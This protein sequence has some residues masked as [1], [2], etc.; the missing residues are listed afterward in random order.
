MKRKNRQKERDFAPLPT[1]LR[2]SL[3]VH[4]FFSY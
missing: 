3:S 1:A 2:K 4:N